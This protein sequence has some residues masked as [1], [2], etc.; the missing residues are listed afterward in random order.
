MHHDDALG[1]YQ[2]G[3]VGMMLDCRPGELLARVAF[4]HHDDEGHTTLKCYTALNG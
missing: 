3:A 1:V 2:P 4:M